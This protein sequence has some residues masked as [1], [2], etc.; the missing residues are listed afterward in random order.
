MKTTIDYTN[1]P[2]A[3]FDAVEDIKN[4]FGNKYDTMAAEFKKLRDVRHFTF[5][6]NFAGVKG[7]PVQAWYDHFFGQGKYN[8]AWDSIESE[9]MP[10]RCD[11]RDAMQESV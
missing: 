3:N 8:A 1:S 11:G 4:W 9:T 7:F 5:Y 2:A 6:C 10:P